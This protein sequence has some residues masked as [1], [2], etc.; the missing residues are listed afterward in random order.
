[1]TTLSDLASLPRAAAIETLSFEDVLA[2]LQ[3]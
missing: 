1:M 3:A 2:Q